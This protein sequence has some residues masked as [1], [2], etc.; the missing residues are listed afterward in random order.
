[1]PEIGNGFDMPARDAFALIRAV[2][3]STDAFA[4]DLAEEFDSLRALQQHLADL[5][6]RPGGLF[7]VARV[8]GDAVG[9]L[10]V[11]PRLR[12]KLRHTAELNM[13]VLRDVRG[14]GVGTRLLTA[15]LEE[16]RR[17]GS[18]EIVYLMVRAD[19]RAALRL[20]R[21]AG[22]IVQARLE[23]DIRVGGRSFDGLLMS[24]FIGS[25]ESSH[26]NFSPSSPH[27]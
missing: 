21:K 2:Y 13:G 9:Y 10:L 1:M 14:K 17:D 27:L 11:E 20:Y 15:A 26:G 25:P 7:L 4:G 3:E 8:G 6:A 24:T 16:L 23:R 18:I 12:A 22:F 5:A 19:N